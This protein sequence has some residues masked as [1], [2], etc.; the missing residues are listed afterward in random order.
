MRLPGVHLYN[1]VHRLSRYDAKHI[2]LTSRPTRRR[3]IAGQI[4]TEFLSL[5][6]G[7]AVAVC[8]AM[9]RS[10][11]VW[12]RILQL[13]EVDEDGADPAVVSIANSLL[14]VRFHARSRFRSLADPCRF[15]I[16]SVHDAADAPGLP[17]GIGAQ[18]TAVREFRRVPLDAS[19]L[20]LTVF[21]ARPGRAAQVVAA[22]AGFAERA[23][24]AY[25]P[26]YLL[27]AR[28]LDDP[29]IS[30][31]LMAVRDAVALSAAAAAAFSL[32]PVR[33]ELDPLLIE[34]PESYAYCPEIDTAPITGALSPYA[35]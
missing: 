19:S 8:L 34:P 9:L 4:A 13:Y 28:S 16:Y 29:R 32:D 2:G 3:S 6:G 21:T 5:A 15:A 14:D 17:L 12:V 7:T 10:R 25:E 26:A 24:D 27:L 31:L 11:S 33:A 35:V 20:A 1:T 30:L 18:L 22:L 23:V